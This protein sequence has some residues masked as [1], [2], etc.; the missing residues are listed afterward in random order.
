MSDWEKRWQEGDTPWDKG[1]AAPPLIEYLG[2]GAGEW[3]EARRILVPGCGSGHDVRALAARGFQ[4]LGVDL[5]ESAVA[6]ARSFRAIGAES[7]VQADLFTLDPAAVGELDGWWEHTCFCAIPPERRPDYALAAARLIR[8]GGWLIGVFFLNPHDED[9]PLLG[10]PF[11]SRK[12]EI[13][14]L[15]SQDF[16]F[17]WG[18]VPEHAYPGREGR[19]WLAAFRRRG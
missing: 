2:L 16:D 5:A 19:E 18:R 15:F 7:Y 6:H 13:I 8:P 14:E 12:E 17:R 4:A 3:A 10:P 11:Q 1:A 9:D